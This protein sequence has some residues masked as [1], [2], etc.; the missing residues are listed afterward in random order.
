MG[1]VC[2]T[3]HFE[4]YFILYQL[5]LPVNLQVD[6]CFWYNLLFFHYVFPRYKEACWTI[7]NS[8]VPSIMWLLQW[9]QA[10]DKRKKFDPLFPIEWMV[11]AYLQLP[12]D[13]SSRVMGAADMRTVV[14][15]R[16]WKRRGTYPFV[17][18]YGCGLLD[19]QRKGGHGKNQY[20]GSAICGRPSTLPTRI[21]RISKQR[22][23]NVGLTGL[24]F[25]RSNE[26]LAVFTCLSEATYTYKC[27]TLNFWRWIELQFSFIQASPLSATDISIINLKGGSDYDVLL[28]IHVLAARLPVKQVLRPTLARFWLGDFDS[29]ENIRIVI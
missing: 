22:M 3:N 25:P 5:P 9:Q 13:T 14:S 12:F 11:K 20:C 21:S 24:P 1:G 7:K 6:A 27:M 2:G 23:G 15:A 10:L 16:R 17:H 19:A 29:V 4:Q 18:D 8:Q 28:L 26:P